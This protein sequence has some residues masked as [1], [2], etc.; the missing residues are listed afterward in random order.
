MLRGMIER[1]AIAAVCGA[2][3]GA[4]LAQSAPMG[5][6]TLAADSKLWVEGGSTVRSYKCVAK[7]I[8]ATV[9]TGPE[10]TAAPL[11][12][13]VK[14]ATVA[15]ATGELDCSNGT[16]N[17]HMRKALKAEQA[18]RIEFTLESYELQAN[19]ASLNGKLQIAGTANAIVFPA[20]I[21][22][23]NGVIRV[24]ASKP[25]NMKEWGIKPPSL[26]MG[27]MKVKEMVTIHFDVTLKR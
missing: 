15:V 12:A 14:G 6:L 17:E 11:P 7:A 10:G 27:T 22:E 9:T 5:S 20:T 3:A 13:L 24:K 25:I 18:P 4:A 2:S 23:E 21:T 19:S 8:D 16:M 26:M 1:L